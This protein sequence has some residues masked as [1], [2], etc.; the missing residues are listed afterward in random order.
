[1]NDRLRADA[2]D[3]AALERPQPLP[4]CAYRRF[5][6][7]TTRWLD[8]DAYGPETRRAATSSTSTSTGRASVRS[9]C[10]SGCSPP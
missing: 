7:V 5:V 6:P 8:N 1:M 10:P 9:P 4:R 2:T 3:L